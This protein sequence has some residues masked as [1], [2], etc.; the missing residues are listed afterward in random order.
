[1][2]ASVAKEKIDYGKRR[3][4][5]FDFERQTHLNPEPEMR[6]T[7]QSPVSGID[8]KSGCPNVVHLSKKN[9]AG[10]TRTDPRS[11]LQVG[12]ETNR[13]SVE[14]SDSVTQVGRILA[15]MKQRKQEMMSLS[16][17]GKCFWIC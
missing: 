11:L 9:N 7:L 3:I 1:V 16:L 8:E 14:K 17:R 13:M 6:R 4:N 5:S 15:M 12:P 10:E 2:K